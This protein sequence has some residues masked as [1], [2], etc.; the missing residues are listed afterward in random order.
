MPD[1]YGDIGFAVIAVAE[2]IDGGCGI[3][4]VQVIGICDG[5]MQARTDRKALLRQPDRR[6]KQAGPFQPAEFL[7]RLP[8]GRNDT[9]CPDRPAAK[10]SVRP[11]KRLAVRL[12]KQ[13][14]VGVKR[15]FFAPVKGGDGGSF[16]A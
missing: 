3:V 16:T 1:G 15:C 11:G 14:L 10:G 9:R 12:Q 6:F 4:C 5:R 13:C 8:E 2:E 7:M